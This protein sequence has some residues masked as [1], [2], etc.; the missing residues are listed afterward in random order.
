MRTVHFRL[1]IDSPLPDDLGL[2]PF[3][4][5]IDLA[6]VARSINASG[7]V[8]IDSVEIVNLTTGQRVEYARGEEF[9]HGAVGRFEWPIAD[10]QH[11]SY[12]VSFRMRPQRS[13][14]HPQV[15]VPMVGT[16][17]VLRYNAGCPRPLTL[18]GSMQLA[19]WSGEGRVDL[20]G[21]WNYY[22]R[23]GEPVSGLVCYPRCADDLCFGDMVRL[24]YRDADGSALQHFAGVYQCADFAD[25][26][27]DGRIDIIF[28]ERGSGRVEFFLQS[29]ERDGGDWPIFRRGP[30]IEVPF[31]DIVDVQWTDV[32]GDGV[33]DLVVNGH[34]MRNENPEGWPFVASQPIDLGAGERVAF[35][36]CEGNVE[37]LS[38]EVGPWRFARSLRWHR[39]LG[40][41]AFADGEVLDLLAPEECCTQLRFVK[42]GQRNGLLVQGNVYQDLRFYAY[43]GALG[44]RP[45]FAA[46]ER[47]QSPSA[48][49]SWSDQAWPCLCD[50]NGDGVYDLLVGGGYGWPRIA[51][52]VG[53]NARPVWQEP[54]LIHAE[55]GPIRILRDEVLGGEHWH[56]MGYP[57]PVWIDWNGDGLP[58]LMLPNETNRIAWYANIG[59][60]QAPRFAARQF[61]EVEGFA[62][63]P[64]LRAASGRDGC[65]PSLAN[66]PYPRDGRSPFFWRTGAAFAD[67]NGDGLMDFITHDAERK[68]VLFVQYR[69]AG[70]ALRVRR[71]GPV[72]L[73]DGRVLCDEIVG[74]QKRWTESFRAVDWD[75]NGLS[76]LIY[77]LAGTG[78]VYLV[79]NVGSREK[80]VFAQPQQMCCYGDPLAFTIHGPNAWPG[81]VNGDG[82]PDLIGCVEWSVYPFFAHAALQMS[83]HPAWHI[84]QVQAV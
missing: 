80:P 10:S 26:D 84:E 50:W 74:R 49:L 57:Y 54:G 37:M 71:E 83:D 9:A 30:S 70:G 63:S 53:T 2:I 81:D 65:D 42:D 78:E 33:P 43:E 15:Y 60:R 12:L 17:D 31:A 11:R 41:G 21:C 58:D 16:G 64:L 13:R 29:H 14:L 62:D 79:R 73:Q 55:G 39:A 19:D 48:V 67:W 52:N 3:A 27:G 20:L 35:F 22:R 69:D 23:P 24:R 4:P 47:L 75:G 7:F 82:K 32:D 28:A 76:D 51:L 56:N 77:S 18:G 46:A 36:A 61:I 45:R 25:I 1:H 66:H 59:T 72:L 68:A 44:G 6:D 34:W 8:D 5:R 38:L 40:S